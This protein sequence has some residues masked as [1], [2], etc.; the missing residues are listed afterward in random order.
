MKKNIGIIG[1]GYWGPNI[2]R[3]LKSNDNVNIKYIC[4]LS[5]EVINKYKNDYLC[6]KNYFDILDDTTVEIVFVITPIST[7][8][9]IIIDCVKYNK[10][11]YVE[12]PICKKQEELD[13]IYE[14]SS[15]NGCKVFC[16]YTFTH[17]DK[18][19]KLKELIN[20][21]QN[22]ILYIEMNRETFGIFS[23]DNVIY[24]LLPHDVSILYHI[25]DTEVKI[26]NYQH[27]KFDNL[28]IKSIINFTIGNMNGTINLS[29]L[30]ESKE[31][32]IKIFCKNK[33]IEYNDISDNIHIF[34][35]HLSIQNNKIE[36]NKKNSED[37]L[38]INYNEPLKTSIYS[39]LNIV[40]NNDEYLYLKNQAI[41]KVVIDCFEKIL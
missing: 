1:L 2:L 29:W 5:D 4:D 31:R 37:I 25:F 9:K 20:Q 17:S 11:V 38:N 39:F 40:D 3:I 7:H 6:T 35:Y 41:N 14:L 27:T 16:D 33:I 36:Q 24:D 12:K 28:I 13:K 30:N 15:K 21:E 8:Y 34:Y 32:K 10:S 22:N 19:N 23:F 18:I 26:N